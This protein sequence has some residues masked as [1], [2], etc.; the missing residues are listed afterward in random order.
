MREEKGG[1]KEKQG[2]GNARSDV[3][4]CCERAQRSPALSRR[5]L[6]LMPAHSGMWRSAA[7]SLKERPQLLQG[8]RLGSGPALGAMGGSGAPLAT[9]AE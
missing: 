8:T 1:R 9:A 6:F 7:F 3:A 5:T 4:L 2:G